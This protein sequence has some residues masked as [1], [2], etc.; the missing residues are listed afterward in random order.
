MTVEE[1]GNKCREIKVDCDKCQYKEACSKFDDLL[2]GIS[3]YM[4][5]TILYD[6]LGVD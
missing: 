2:D 6:E 5:L 3:P 1:L 4:I